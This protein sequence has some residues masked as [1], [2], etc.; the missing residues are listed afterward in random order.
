MKPDRRSPSERLRQ[1]FAAN[2][3]RLEETRRLYYGGEGFPS[4][5][6]EDTPAMN[7]VRFLQAI[8]KVRRVC[9]DEGL[10]P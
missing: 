10:N 6:G 1:H 8:G 7:M 5:Y 2:P 3:D 4:S 9:A